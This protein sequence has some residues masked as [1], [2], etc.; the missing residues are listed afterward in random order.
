M[1][2]NADEYEPHDDLKIPRDALADGGSVTREYVI[3]PGDAFVLQ[4]GEA[5]IF[6]FYRTKK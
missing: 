5:Y 6:Y 3:V 1:I 4:K 2:R